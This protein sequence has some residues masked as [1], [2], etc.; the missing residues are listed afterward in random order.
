MTAEK[1]SGF[2]FM[3]NS[4]TKPQSYVYRVFGMPKEKKEIVEKIKPGTRLFLYDFK[5]KLVYG[6][7]RATSQR[8]MDLEPDA[9]GGAFPAQHGCTLKVPTR[10]VMRIITE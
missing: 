10:Q 6:V 9:F 1:S 7:Y 8:G 5:L 2:I 3:C 4:W